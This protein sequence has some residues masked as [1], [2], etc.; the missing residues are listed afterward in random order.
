[1]ITEEQQ[2]FNFDIRQGQ[3]ENYILKTRTGTD[4]ET[5]FCHHFRFG[6]A[7]LRMKKQKDKGGKKS[8]VDPKDICNNYKKLGYWKRNCLKKEKKYFCCCSCSK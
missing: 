2:E 4:M 6:A 5:Y 3:I 7:V 1:M 8:K